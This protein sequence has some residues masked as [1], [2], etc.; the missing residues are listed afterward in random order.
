[1]PHRATT[2]GGLALAVLFV[3][4]AVNLF[5]FGHLVPG[6]VTRSESTASYREWMGKMFG[7]VPDL[8]P[9]L[10]TRVRTL[11]DER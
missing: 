2:N 1:V 11:T 10:H 4:V 3:V 8:G 9:G 5:L 6:V 7:H